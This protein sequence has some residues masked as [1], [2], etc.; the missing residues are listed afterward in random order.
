MTNG[1]KFKTA[2]EREIE[3]D[4]FC[5]SSSKT[6]ENCV[7][8]DCCTV[9]ECSFAWLDLEYK[10]PPKTMEEIIAE[11]RDISTTPQIPSLLFYEQDIPTIRG[12]EI[13]RYLIDLAKE[14]EVA[15]NRRVK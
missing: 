1:E 8:K 4:R 12:K 9:N 7:L 14:I 11:L 5:T 15:W 2:K 3:F 10:R 13:R 6:C